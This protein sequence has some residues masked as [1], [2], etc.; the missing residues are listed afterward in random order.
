MTADINPM[1]TP[2]QRAQRVAALLAVARC[3]VLLAAR[4]GPVRDRWLDMLREFLPAAS[5]WRRLPPHVPL[6][7]L[8]GGLDL[9]ATLATGRPM[10]EQGLLG[11]A[12]G[13]TV[14]VPMAERLDASAAALLCAALDHGEIQVEREGL[15]ARTAARID[16]V[17][18]DERASDDEAVPAALE[19]RL[20]LRLALDDIGPR[21]LTP[22]TLSRAE[23]D[24]ARARYLDASL[25]DSLLTALVEAAASVGI[26]SLRVVM[27]A[28]R[29]ARAAA[30]LDGVDTVDQHHAALAAQLVL[31]PRAVCFAPPPEMPP[32]PPEQSTQESSDAE[33]Q[34]QTQADEQRELLVAAT[35]AAIPD[36][37][38]RALAQGG[39][40]R[41]R[42][43]GGRAGQ[44]AETQG[45]GRPLPPRAGVPRGGQRL[46][47]IATLRAAAPWQKLRAPSAGASRTCVALR[48]TDLRTVRRQQRRRSLTVFVVDASGSTAARRLAEAKGAIELMLAECYVRRDRVAL[49]AFRGAG[50]ELVLAPTRALTRARRCLADLPG[51]GGSPLASGLALAREVAGS[52][53][54]EDLTPLIVVLTD[55]RPNVDLSGRGGAEQAA[56]DA[57][58]VADEIAQ[59]ALPAVMID[60]APRPRDFG[61]E[62]ASRM[63]ARYLPLPNADAHSIA[64]A[65]RAALPS[66][67]R[68]AHG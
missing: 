25:S 34:D 3:G 39:A 18:L 28:A 67:P 9:G 19:E 56:R 23:L 11:G 37:V 24:A 60:V 7:R 31:A 49:V 42:R 36:D 51:G 68:V 33:A 48:A 50:A 32:P 8:V 64:G 27:L 35:Q 10:L 43:G 16:V 63:H 4:P 6:A 22:A 59:L 58:T 41:A 30:A 65:A 55:G 57:L 52:A 14:L 20:A 1:L 47:L 5:P 66:T 15:S 62:L 12:D 53:R 13:G 45:R 29:V 38:L 61:A 54:G 40:R 2:W 17:A 21:E 26:G 46:D 44:R